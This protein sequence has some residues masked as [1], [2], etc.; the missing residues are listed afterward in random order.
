MH[1]GILRLQQLLLAMHGLVCLQQPHVEMSP[2]DAMRRLAKECEHL[3]VHA[4]DVYGDFPN[5]KTT[6]SATTNSVEE[7]DKFGSSRSVLRRLEN[8]L[9]QAFGK[10]DAVFLPSG[11][12]AQAI[13]LLIHRDNWNKSS[14]KKRKKTDTNEESPHADTTTVRHCNAFACHH[15]SHLLLHEEDSYHELLGMQ[16]FILSTINKNPEEQGDWHVPPLTYDH[17]QQHELSGGGLDVHTLLLELPHRELGGKLTPWK[18]VLQMSAYCRAQGIAFHCDGARIFEAAAGY[19]KFE[20]SSS[21]MDAPMMP[22]EE[23]ARP[24]DSVYI[25]FYKGLGGLSGAM[26]LGTRDFCNQARVWLRRFGG[27]LYTLLPYAVAGWAG[28]RRHVL[29]LPSGDADEGNDDKNG[30]RKLLSFAQKQQKLVVIVAALSIDPIISSIV[31]FDPRVPLTNMVH[32]YFRYEPAT[33]QAALDQV[34]KQTGVQ[35]LRRVKPVPEH[36]PAFAAGYRSTFEWVIGEFNGNLP[37]DV[38][39]SGWSHLATVLLNNG[40]EE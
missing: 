7:K 39:L 33:C 8:E 22:L 32:G 34:F 21:S 27:N 38:F 1:D 28:Y 23:L 5:S 17:V 3:N 9:S 13:A 10:E 16:A 18:D 4:W 6:T 26:L 19:A 37:H 11:V 12:M 20:T 29:L 25:S 36:H 30:E 2:A 15:S 14:E 35:V 31:S 40:R 24:F